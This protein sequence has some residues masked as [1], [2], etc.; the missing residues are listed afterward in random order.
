[1]IFIFPCLSLYIHTSI[2]TPISVVV[3]LPMYTAYM[4]FTYAYTVV[5]KYVFLHQALIHSPVN[6]QF[7]CNSCLE[8][9]YVTQLLSSCLLHTTVIFL[10]LYPFV[11]QFLHLQMGTAQVSLPKSQGFCDDKVRS[12]L[13][14]YFKITW[15][16]PITMW[17]TS[18]KNYTKVSEWLIWAFISVYNYIAGP[19][20]FWGFYNYKY[21]QCQSI[22][23]YRNLRS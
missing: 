5:V 20:I 16:N 8:I 13:A 3:Y 19:V 9:D 11:H 1:M 2:S 14:K 4:S 17:W 7:A 22:Y 12:Y 15:Y 6:M 21:Y 23:H 10:D 18:V